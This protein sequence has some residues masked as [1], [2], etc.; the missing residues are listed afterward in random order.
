MPMSNQLKRKELRLEINGHH[1]DCFETGS[2]SPIILF[3]STSVE[4]DDPAL[5]KLAAAH[6]LICL[7]LSSR[8]FATAKL[9]SEKLPG[10]LT[11]MGVEQF[12]VIGTGAGVLPALA[13]AIATSERVS[14]LILVSP[15]LPRETELPDFE[16]VKA[17]TLVLVGTQLGCD[18]SRASMLRKNM[19][20][21]SLA[22]LW[23]RSCAGE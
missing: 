10:V 2:G 5:I 17:E 20:L 14:R 1:I 21:P 9:L 8:D 6:R 16:R 4:I 3:L 18:W 22:R 23:S 19:F 15:L 12:S 7:N 13:L 11:N